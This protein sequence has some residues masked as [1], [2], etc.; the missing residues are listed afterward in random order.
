MPSR[1]AFPVLVSVLLAVPAY[2]DT[3]L[4]KN[5]RSFEG[6][7]AEDSGSVVH[8]RMSGAT[9]SLPA[10][11]I[12]RIDKGEAPFALYQSRKGALR[13]NPAT[14]AADWL[15][16]AVWAR[17]NDLERESREAVLTAADLDPRLPGL[18]P[19]MRVLGYTYD[20]Q[21]DRYIPYADA[22]RRKGMVMADG[23]WITQDEHRLRSERN[24]REAARLRA[25]RAEH[26]A[27]RAESRRQADLA[28]EQEQ[29][30]LERERLARLAEVPA[31]SG[32]PPLYYYVSPIFVGPLQPPS[33]DG[34]HGHHHGRNRRPSSNDS[35]LTRQPGSLLPG[36]VPNSPPRHNS[37]SWSRRR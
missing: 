19:L 11:N 31:L 30:R 3:V 18:Q 4:L 21:M 35:I 16:L 10:S 20:E 36:L 23:Q 15:E 34:G 14:G 33:P 25:E 17:R 26:E 29:L 8:I 37:S 32:I 22:M 6:V 2:A 9:L 13:K 28:R 7:V 24:E 27:R 5:G 1:L 12:L